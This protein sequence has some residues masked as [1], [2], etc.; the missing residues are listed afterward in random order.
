MTGAGPVALVLVLAAA[1][2][3][4]DTW[5]VNNQTG[6]DGNDGQSAKTAFA[7]IAKA[8]AAARTSDTIVLANTGLPYREPIAMRRL[9]G[10]PS[11]PF[12]IDA[13]PGPGAT[14][15]PVD[16]NLVIGFN[17]AMDIA[18]VADAFILRETVSGTVV[19]DAATSGGSMSWNPA[20]TVMTFNP[21][22][23]LTTG[24][25]YTV[26]FLAGTA[27]DVAGNTMALVSYTFT[28]AP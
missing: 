19:H 2:A 20:S 24:L 3:W 23:D 16:S 18:S 11:A 8:V 13:Y 21:S 27:A 17:E 28:T 26:E 12:V 4:A 22:V 6:D 10:M 1:V 15:V 14:N 5:H 9:G 7:T 25:Q